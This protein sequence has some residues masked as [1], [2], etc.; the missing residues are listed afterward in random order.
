MARRHFEQ[1]GFPNIER[2]IK[3]I[4]SYV[5]ELELE[6]TGLESEYPDRP[7]Q[8]NIINSKKTRYG[9]RVI[10]SDLSLVEGLPK[11]PFK[12]NEIYVVGSQVEYLPD[13]YLT[14][15]HD[16]D[17]V[18]TTNAEAVTGS[19]LVEYE[20]L[21]N[22]LNILNNLRREHIHEDFYK[23]KEFVIGLVD[24]Q[25]HNPLEPPYLQIH[26]IMKKVEGEKSDII[27]PVE[28]TE[29]DRLYTAS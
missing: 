20:I 10:S 17:L 27:L 4:C 16:L 28:I 14:G 29:N 11:R 2:I 13:S 26:P 18:V 15:E 3:E 8:G 5:G 6:Y 19:S 24:A 1:N 25:P 21:S 23:T 22:L 9:R 12:V 7:L